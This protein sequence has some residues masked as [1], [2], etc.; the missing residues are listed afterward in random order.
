MLQVHFS[1]HASIDKEQSGGKTDLT[2][3]EEGAL[4]QIKTERLSTE[5]VVENEGSLGEQPS[6]HVVGFISFFST[7]G[8][9]IYRHY[10]TIPLSDFGSGYFYYPPFITF[11][12]SIRKKK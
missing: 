8:Y 11:F 10:P 12:F 9:K 6:F 2:L 3:P 1:T 5:G 4:K 7:G